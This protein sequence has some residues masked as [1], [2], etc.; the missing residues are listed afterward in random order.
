MVQRPADPAAQDRTREMPI[1]KRYFDLIASGRKTVEVRVAYPSNLRLAAGQLLRFTCPGEQCLTRIQRITRYN[2]F[3]DMLDH[4][5]PA[6]VNPDASRDEQL[7]SIRLIYPSEKE[8]L[9]V[10]AIQVTRV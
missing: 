10:L 9:G 4:E 2:S 5:D 7:A 1:Y 3:E 8:A 6:A